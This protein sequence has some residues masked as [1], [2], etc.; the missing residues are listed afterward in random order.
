MIQGQRTDNW[1][2]ADLV[3]EVVS[4]DDPDRDYTTKRED[5]AQAGVLEY[6]IVDPQEE[7]TT[8]LH[9]VEARYEEH[10][11]FGR[12]ATVTSAQFPEFEIAVDAVLDAG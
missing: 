3:V 1:E 2:G 5:Y 6:W 4:P 11:I 12:G 7:K 9:L 8:V 10:G